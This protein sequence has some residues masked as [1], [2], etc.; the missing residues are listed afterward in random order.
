MTKFEDISA[1]LNRGAKVIVGLNTYKGMADLPKFVAKYEDEQGD[2]G[3]LV[4]AQTRIFEPGVKYV[5]RARF[6]N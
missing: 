2:K 1:A 4:Y 3:L 5:T 6:G